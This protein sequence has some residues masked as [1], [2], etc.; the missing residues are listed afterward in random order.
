M[1][2]KRFS[3][4]VVKFSNKKTKR[5]LK[6]SRRPS[7]EYQPG[8]DKMLELCELC[9][10]EDCI[11]AEGD[12]RNIGAWSDYPGCLIWEKENEK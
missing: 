5:D 7:G 10:L 4:P 6:R 11:R 1:K 8:K 3:I 9:Q 12:F 2:P